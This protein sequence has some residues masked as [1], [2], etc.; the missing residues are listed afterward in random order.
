MKLVC[1]PGDNRELVYSNPERTRYTEGVV[2]LRCSYKGTPGTFMNAMWVSKDWSMLFGNFMGWPKK[3]ANIHLTYVPPNHPTL[4]PIGVGSNLRGVVAR[5]GYRILDLSVRLDTREEDSAAPQFGW[6]YAVR[7]YPGIGPTLPGVKQ[8]IRNRIKGPP[9]NQRVF[10]RGQCRVRRLRQRGTSATQTR[11]DY[12]GLLLQPQ[13][14]LD[15]H[16]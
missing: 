12:Q 11:G 3:I 1:V 8:L 14:D 9:L 15:P 10:R 2:G 7:Y 5:E 6:L 4:Q 16:G 13:L